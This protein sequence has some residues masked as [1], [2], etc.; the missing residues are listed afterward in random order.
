MKVGNVATDWS[1]P[2]ATRL[3]AEPTAT[4]PPISG[5]PIR[6]PW[7]KPCPD[8]LTPQ[9][10]VSLPALVLTTSTVL[11]E[12]AGR[13]FRPASTNMLLRRRLMATVPVTP[14]PPVVARVAAVQD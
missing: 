5:S 4:T 7:Q 10:M 12:L 13:P 8:A 3:P 14:L 6:S 2:E 11:L 1:V 9:L